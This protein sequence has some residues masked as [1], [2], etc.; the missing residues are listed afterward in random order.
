VFFFVHLQR[1]RPA[2]SFK[3]C[4]GTKQGSQCKPES[5]SFFSSSKFRFKSLQKWLKNTSVGPVCVCIIIDFSLPLESRIKTLP[6]E[7]ISSKK[8]NGIIF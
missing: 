2:K 3:Y 4:R 5:K 8:V 1:T 6:F 7:I